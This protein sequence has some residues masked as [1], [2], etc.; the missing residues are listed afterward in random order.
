M[1]TQCVTHVHPNF[2]DHGFAAV[3]H[4]QTLSIEI[5]CNDVLGLE[6]VSILTKHWEKDLY[7]LRWLE[8]GGEGNDRLVQS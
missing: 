6:V 4:F 1:C 8:G 3:Q 7:E 2:G 5:R